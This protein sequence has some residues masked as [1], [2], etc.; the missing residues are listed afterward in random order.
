MSSEAEASESSDEEERL[1]QGGEADRRRD[2][3]ALRAYQLQRLKYYY[4]VIECDTAETAA[5][6]Y[7]QCDGL[8]YETTSNIMDLR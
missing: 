3:E 5:A 4:A 6:I 1:E 2:E 8:E 7:E